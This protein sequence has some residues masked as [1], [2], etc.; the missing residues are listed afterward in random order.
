M[1]FAQIL[2][3]PLFLNVLKVFTLGVL[4]FVVAIAWTPLLT[5]FL[6]SKSFRSK[7]KEKTVSGETAPITK[8]VTAGKEGTPLMGGLLVWVTAFFLGIFFYILSQFQVSDFWKSLNFLFHSRQTWLPMFA[9][10]MTGVLGLIDDYCTSRGIGKNK[11]G[12]APFV[13][14]FMGLIVIALAGSLWFHYKLGYS[15][16]HVPGMGD[17]VMGGWYLLYFI[18]IIVATAI[19][20]NETDGLDGLN[21]GVLLFAFASYSFIAFFQ[22]RVDLAAFC[23]VLCGGL[24]AFL[25]FNIHPA[26]FFMGETGAFSLGT[27]L[28]VVA[29]LTNTSLVLPF[30]A[31]IYVIESLSVIVQI[32]SKKLRGGKKVFLA[33][34]IHYHFRALGWPES[35][36]VMRFWIISAVMSVIGIVVGIL[37]GG[38]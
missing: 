23:A 4:A 3:V 38:K 2:T 36:V 1:Q 13:Y 37:G 16:I 11:G 35:K 31:F 27:T 17:I 32:A 9:L 18:F 8:Q 22:G 19:S 10:V 7:Q 6:Y 34:P 20:S 29:M 5:K 14:R 21:G 26:R 30:I 24:L 12:G 28:G 33:A 25:W 15:S